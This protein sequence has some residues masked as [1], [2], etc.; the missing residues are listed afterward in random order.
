MSSPNKPSKYSESWSNC[1]ISQ[2]KGDILCEMRFHIP[3][4]E[5]DAY[6]AEKN[7]DREENKDDQEESEEE[8]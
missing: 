1:A 8:D 5:L 2:T 7:K 6:L 4:N 3:N